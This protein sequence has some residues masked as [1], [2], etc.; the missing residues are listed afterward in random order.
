[1]AHRFPAATF[2]DRDL[3]EVR[4]YRLADVQPHQ[5]VV[6][7]RYSMVSTGTELRVLGG[8]Y[9][10]AG[11]YPA[12]PGYASVGEVVEVGS[13]VK[14]FRVGDRVS[15]RNPQPVPG[16]TNFFWGGQSALQL[17]VEEGMDRPVRLP[18]GAEFRDYVTVEIATISLR[19]V[20]QADPQPGETAVVLGQGVDRRILGGVAV[21]PRLP[22]DRRGPSAGSTPTRTQVGG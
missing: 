11:R 18:A 2:V 15:C 5:F 9:G 21:G 20:T 3:V 17:H 4:E 19:G 6:K 1:M 14:G 10:V 8:H 7:T 22:G 16:V 12:I 13:E